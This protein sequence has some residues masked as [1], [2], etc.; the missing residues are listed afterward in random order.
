VISPLTFIVPWVLLSL[1]ATPL[2]GAIIARTLGIEDDLDR[3]DD[4]IAS[5]IA[6]D[7]DEV[8]NGVAPILGASGEDDSR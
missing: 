3:N 1:L 2:L 7:R 8:E 6:S 4:S 5:E